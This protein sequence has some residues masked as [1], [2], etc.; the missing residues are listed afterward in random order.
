MGAWEEIVD[1]TVPSNTTSVTLNNFGT[2]TK[3]DFIKVVT[4]FQNTSSP[5]IEIRTF[6]NTNSGVSGN[7]T[8]TNY[9]TQ[10]LYGDGSSVVANRLN[11]NRH[12]SLDS[13]QTGTTISYIK[14]SENNKYNM[15]SNTFGRNNSNVYNFFLYTTSTID[16]NNSITSLE[17]SSTLS[18]KIGT[19]TRI[20]IYRLAAEKVADIVVSSNTTQVDITGLNIGK[21]SE[22]LLVSSVVSNNNNFGNNLFINDNTTTTNYYN[23]RIY[24]N[25]SSAIASRENSA[26]F[27]VV[28]GTGATSVSY[29]HIK[30]SNIGAYTFQSYYNR[31]SGTSNIWVSNRFGSSTAENITSITKLN[32]RASEQTDGIGTGTRFELYKLY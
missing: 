18:N 30:L 27:N 7:N 16:F 14:I 3:D 19:G 21:D 12:T 31:D 26:V 15:F 25:G 11:E 2:I 13:N 5:G 9:Y 22:Y 17:F 29:T 28:D 23:Q 1:Y 4:T 10:Q 32:I 8:T 20:Q 24:G 6:P